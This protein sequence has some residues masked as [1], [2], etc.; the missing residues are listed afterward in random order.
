L[1]SQRPQIRSALRRGYL[2]FSLTGYLRPLRAASYFCLVSVPII[3][4]SASVRTTHSPSWHWNRPKYPPASSQ[5]SWTM[6]APE[7]ASLTIWPR[8]KSRNL[9]IPCT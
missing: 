4:S 2:S 9:R 3:D 6:A 7:P 5:M 8:F 1:A